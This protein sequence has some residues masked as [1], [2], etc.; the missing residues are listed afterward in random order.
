LCNGDHI[1]LILIRGT[2]LAEEKLEGIFALPL[3]LTCN[4]VLPII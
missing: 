3:D 1:W 4:Q 2:V